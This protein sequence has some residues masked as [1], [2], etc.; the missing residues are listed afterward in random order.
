[1]LTI[2]NV[3]VDITKLRAC[4]WVYQLAVSGKSYPTNP[5]GVGLAKRLMLSP[6]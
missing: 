2:E 5:S 6:V 4:Q 3:I 1:M